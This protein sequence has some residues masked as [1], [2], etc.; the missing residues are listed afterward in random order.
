MKILEAIE[1]RILRQ[2]A[3]PVRF[4]TVIADEDISEAGPYDDLYEIRHSITVYVDQIGPRDASGEMMR[5][6]RGLLAKQI[7]GEVED[8]LMEL[9]H[10]LYKEGDF[11]RNSPVIQKMDEML[12]EIREWSR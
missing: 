6:A 1:A 2:K 5:R 9:L 11:Q 8:N 10:I 7:Y 12:S 4:A 3:P